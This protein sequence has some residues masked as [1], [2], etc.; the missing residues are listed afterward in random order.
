MGDKKFENYNR[1]KP[2]VVEDEQVS[3]DRKRTGI[4]R[5]L[6]LRLRSRPYNDEPNE[7]GVLN[8]SERV[9]I[10][11]DMGDWLKVQTED[12][13]VGYVVTHYIKEE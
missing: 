6:L 5:C 11:K 10:L 13:R 9:T 4:V 2:R 3:K 7:I 12:G 8:E 1:P